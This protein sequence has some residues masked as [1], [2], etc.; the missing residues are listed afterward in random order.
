MAR[1]LR[2]AAAPGIFT[3]ANR[4]PVPNPSAARGQVITLYVTGAGAV[5]PAIATGAAAASGTPAANLPKPVQAATVTVGGVAAPIQFIG[6]PSGVVGVTQINYQVR[7][8][9]STGTQSVVVTVGGVS[10]PPANL[11]VTQ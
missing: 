11:L 1:A 8:S 5:K 10:S 7:G 6:I 4:A 2:A 9:V 3:D